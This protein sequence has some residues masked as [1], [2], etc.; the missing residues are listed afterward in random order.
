MQALE[1]N[2]YLPPKW[3]LLMES[4]FLDTRN[5]QNPYMIIYKFLCK[6]MKSMILLEWKKVNKLIPENQRVNKN[7]LKY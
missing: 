2:K 6:E 3:L 4:I 7:Y 1:E 5:V